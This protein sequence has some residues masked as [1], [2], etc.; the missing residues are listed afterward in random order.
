MPEITAF[1]CVNCGTDFT[2]PHFTGCP[3]CRQAGT[4]AN[5][6]PLYPPDPRSPDAVKADWASG[7][8]PGVW[9]FA[10]RLPHI[11]AACRLSLGEGNTPLIPLPRLG[12]AL[13]PVELW[14]KDESRNPT[15]S[16]KDRLMAVAVSAGLAAGATAV[17][18]SSTGNAGA[19]LAA[20]AGRGGLPAYIF[21]TAPLPEPMRALMQSYGARLFTVPTR[22]DRFKLVQQGM[23]RRGWYPATNL[24]EPPVGSN[25]LGVE[26]YKTLAFEVALALNFA[27]PDAIVVPTSNGDGL[28]GMWRGLAE[29]QEL[30]LARR[31]PRLVAARPAQKETV[32]FSLGK[33][34]E[35]LQVTLALKQSNGQTCFVPEDEIIAMQL[36]LAQTEGLYLEAASV[37]GLCALAQLT[38]PASSRVVVVGTSTGLKDPAATLRRLPPPPA[39][40]GRLAAVPEG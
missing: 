32:A 4:P 16:W 25:C 12:R 24:S 11:P 17:A 15:W 10:D 1:R 33:P 30:G 5:L 13:G 31:A 19:S 37:V 20:Y 2:E 21:A 9:R 14:L 23:A 29:L 39:I 18:G 34:P 40:E 38:L 27:M 7:K 36:R 3:R 26:G 22:E 8:G 28:F 35:A 6:Y